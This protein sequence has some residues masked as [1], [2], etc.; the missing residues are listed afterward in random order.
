MWAEIPRTLA[1]DW[2][3][4]RFTRLDDEWISPNSPAQMMS[5]IRLTGGL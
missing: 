3:I 4:P 2:W 1:S 5:R